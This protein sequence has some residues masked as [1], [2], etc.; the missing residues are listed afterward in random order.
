VNELEALP[1]EP[2]EQECKLAIMRTA[3][4]LHPFDAA[5]ATMRQSYLLAEK[6]TC[7]G[8]LS[9]EALASLGARA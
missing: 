9:Y 4:I 2:T 6:G 5:Y 1:G 7:V 3:M 8:E